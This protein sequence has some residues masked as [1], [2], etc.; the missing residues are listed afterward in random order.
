METE[1]PLSILPS[2]KCSDCGAEIKI[3]AMGEH[4]CP[5][6]QDEPAPSSTWQKPKSPTTSPFTPPATSPVSPPI[7]SPSA[8]KQRSLL[9]PMEQSLNRPPSRPAR[10]PLP[11][12]DPNV[13]NKPY[14]ARQEMLSPDGSNSSGRRTPLTPLTGRP[15]R[16]PGMR[17]ATS[18]SPRLPREPSQELTGNMDCAFPPFPTARSK[19]AARVKSPVPDAY[20]APRSPVGNGG[21]IVSRKLDTIAPGPFNAPTRNS[22]RSPSSNVGA[23]APPAITIDQ[24]PA[25]R[26]ASPIFRSA[27]PVSYERPASPPTRSASPPSPVP[28]SPTLSSASTASVGTNREGRPIPQRPVRPEPLDGFLAMLKSE[29]EAAGQQLSN[30]TIRSNTFPLPPSTSKSPELGSV[31]RSPSAP[32][33]RQRRPT[34]SAPSQ[35]A[36]GASLPTVSSTGPPALPPL[37][38]ISTAVAPALPPLPSAADLQKHAHPIVHA[39]SDSASSASSAQSFKSDISPPVSASSSVSMLSTTLSDLSDPS[40]LVP[41]LQVKSKQIN[42][43]SPDDAFKPSFVAERQPAPAPFEERLDSPTE[44]MNHF[45]VGTPRISREADYPESPVV[46]GFHVKRPLSPMSTTSTPM[47][48]P[49]TEHGFCSRPTSSK[50]PGTS[51]KHICRGCSEPI[52]GKSVKAADGRLTGRYHKHCFVC[53]TCKSAFATADFYVIDNNPYCEHHYHELNNSLCAHC[54][55]GI[56]GPYLETQQ[57]QKF[58]PSCFTCIDCHKPLS[59]DYFEIAGKVYCEQ[60]AFASVRQQEGLGPK[61]NMER[62]TTRFMVM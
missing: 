32:P 28:A 52:Q 40:L 29:S 6:Q 25:E 19:S 56:E 48:S 4:V 15:G 38:T 2:I 14:T 23:Q 37:P 49:P 11:R 43:L 7:T 31:L 35:S 47:A 27:S 21:A 10:N 46:P 20:Y 3:S 42:R 53:K 18:P 5:A 36:P 1:R 16:S 9:P 30:M 22:S 57:T 58:H 24:P 26:A 44:K 55:R 59:D 51:S 33:T 41:S 39:P 61:R 62:R 12:I 50:R 8:A 34:I 17:S 13:A 54:D 60:H 45:P